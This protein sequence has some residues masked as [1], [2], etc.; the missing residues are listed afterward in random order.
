VVASFAALILA[1]CAADP[2]VLTPTATPFPEVEVEQIVPSPSPAIHVSMWWNEEIAQRDLDLVQG[3]GFRWIKQAFSWRDIETN[4]R[5]HY[6]WWRTD[7]I[8]RNAEERGLNLIVRLDR[9]PFWSQS[10]GGE[11][12]LENAPPADLQDFGDFCYAVAGR[13]RGQ[14]EA[15][16]V[17]NE[18]NL[19]REWGGQPPDPVA[20]T[21]L[22]AV[23]YEAIKR[24]DPHAIVISAGPA[25]TG[26]GFPEAMPD[27]EFVRGMYEAGAAQYFDML[28]VNAPGYAAPPEVSPEEAASTPAYGG[29]RWNAFRH[30]EDIRQIMLMYGDSQKQIAILEMGW[31]TDPVHPEYSWFRV[32]EEQQ[33]EY[34]VNAYWYAYEH[35]RPWIGIMTAVYIADPYWTPEDEQYWWSISLPNWPETITRP[36]YDTLGE[37]PDW[38]GPLLIPSSGD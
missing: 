17:W 8:V 23:C 33:A 11:L 20:Y 30:V 38:G 27:D 16:Q 29:H 7:R 10:D 18:P 32:S 12:P 6:D 31:T 24:G 28:G 4:Q 25:P 13:Y 2:P 5:G 19:A 37:L 21:E 22:L 3:M 15:Y 26:T 14:I 35:W 1:G 34:L 36:A 9:Q